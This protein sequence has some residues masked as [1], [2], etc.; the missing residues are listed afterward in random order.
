MAHYL[1]FLSSILHQRPNSSVLFMPE[2]SQVLSWRGL[3]YDLLEPWSRPDQYD[4]HE[5][6]AIAH[7]LDPQQTGRVTREQALQV[8]FVLCSEP[9]LIFRPGTH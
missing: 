3:L 5:A 4:L 7:V 1:P 9:C 6:L 2:S 8:R